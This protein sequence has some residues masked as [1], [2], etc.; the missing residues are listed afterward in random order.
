MPRKTI[1]KRCNVT[2]K[3]YKKIASIKTKRQQTKRVKNSRNKRSGKRGG[4]QTRNWR[5]FLKDTTQQLQNAAKGTVITNQVVQTLG[6]NAETINQ[7]QSA[8][9]AMQNQVDKQLAKF[10]RT[11]EENLRKRFQKECNGDSRCV[12][13]KQ[14]DFFE[15]ER[16]ENMRRTAAND[17]F[18]ASLV[19]MDSSLPMYQNMSNVELFT[20]IV[21]NWEEIETN[22]AL[23]SAVQSYYKCPG[24]NTPQA[25]LDCFKI[26]ADEVFK[27]A[28]NQFE[29]KLHKYI[30]QYLTKNA[31]NSAKAGVTMVA[32]AFRAAPDYAKRLYNA[33]PKNRENMQQLTQ[34]SR[35]NIAPAFGQVKSMI[36]ETHHKHIDKMKDFLLQLHDIA[37][38]LAGLQE[39]VSE[40][41]QAAE[42]SD[43]GEFKDA[44]EE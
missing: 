37:S 8:F 23:I 38:K 4:A 14:A 1:K 17:A 24:P 22:L 41:E 34:Q 21:D 42:E 6:E 31:S 39:E 36:P 35:S 11:K 12:V 33:S 40:I 43:G 9:L 7:L 19:R 29:S 5:G 26:K 10:K 3:S 20:A 25:L 2:K 27:G 44:F 28:V 30:D 18:W 16:T 32:N 13:E 15:K